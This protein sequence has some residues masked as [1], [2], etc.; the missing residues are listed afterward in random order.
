MSRFIFFTPRLTR[1]QVINSSR[2]NKCFYHF[3]YHYS[4]IDSALCFNC[5]GSGHWAKECPEP[6]RVKRRPYRAPPSTITS[7]SSSSYSSHS[8]PRRYSRQDRSYDTSP[9][10]RYY[11]S[12]RPSERYYYVTDQRGSWENDHDD[13]GFHHVRPHHTSKYHGHERDR[14]SSSSNTH[15]I[16]YAH[17]HH[18]NPPRSSIRYMRPPSPLIHYVKNY[19]DHHDERY[20]VHYDDDAPPPSSSSPPPRKRRKFYEQ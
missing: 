6:N 20:I 1:F 19:K 8:P 17:Q 9:P 13:D 5:Q 3:L 14:F 16:G 7:S 4:C 12:S 11:S 2:A 18:T 10:L 15:R